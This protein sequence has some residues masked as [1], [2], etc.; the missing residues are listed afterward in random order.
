MAAMMS[1]ENHPLA[2]K[3]CKDHTLQNSFQ[4]AV[5]IQEF[6]VLTSYC[7]GSQRFAASSNEILVFVS[8]GRDKQF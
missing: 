1:R 6:H 7:L 4:S 2:P 5:Q 3:N 8:I